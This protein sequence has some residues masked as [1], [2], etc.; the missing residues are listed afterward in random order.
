MWIVTTTRG[1][2]MTS[3]KS[4][5][6]GL[7]ACFALSSTAAP[8]QLKLPVYMHVVHS[9]PSDNLQLGPLPGLVVYVLLLRLLL[10]CALLCRFARMMLTDE[11]DRRGTRTSLEG[12]VHYRTGS[13]TPRMPTTSEGGSH[14]HHHS[15]SVTTDLPGAAS[16][17]GSGRTHSVKLDADTKHTMHGVK[18]GAWLSLGQVRATELALE[19]A[20]GPYSRQPTQ[21]SGN[22]S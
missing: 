20:I 10:R 3:E 21:L 4:R 13:A 11:F 18:S 6:L 19:E 1:L 12:H 7:L 17:V 5:H 8:A 9:L 2:I 22:G 16:N 15:N 14:S